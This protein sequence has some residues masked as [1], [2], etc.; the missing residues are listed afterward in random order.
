M[1]ADPTTNVASTEPL[2]CPSCCAK[3]RDSGATDSDPPSRS[4]PPASSVCSR[5][6][7]R[8]EHQ[9]LLLSVL[10]RVTTANYDVVKKELLDQICPLSEQDDVETVVQS[11]YEKAVQPDEDL[12]TGLYAKLFADVIE[13]ETP[14]VAAMLRNAIRH[15]CVEQL[16]GPTALS[17]P[18]DNTT[19]AAH[20]TVCPPPCL[21]P[22]LV[23]GCT[24]TNEDPPGDEQNAS[25]VES[26]GR[27][28]VETVTIDDAGDMP[29]ALHPRRT[30]DNAARRQQR[31]RDRHRRNVAFLG[32]LFTCDVVDGDVM[33]EA[34]QYL[35][36][37]G[38][39]ASRD[40]PS[41]AAA[42]ASTASGEQPAATT[43]GGEVG[44]TSGTVRAAA[45]HIVHADVDE[46]RLTMFADVLPS[47]VAHLSSDA[48]GRL[49]QYLSRVR[50]LI[51]TA[52][53]MTASSSE[54]VV[55]A[56]EGEEEGSIRPT[57]VD[58]DTKA[59][60]ALSSRQQGIS[61]RTA[62]LLQNLIDRAADDW[63]ARKPGPR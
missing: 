62:V 8:S 12:F 9:R 53:A 25:R 37:Q 48:T 59:P 3:Q 46:L 21:R 7:R 15:R 10:N 20:S 29:D 41:P 4:S 27:R 38:V 57:T 16:H 35:L 61:R 18:S 55:P 40:G 24:P 34:L 44:A 49:P 26:D 33:D 45:A 19:G 30:V 50:E 56:K 23:A 11:F 22:H 63:R 52:Y 58:D 17:D 32:H 2:H 42:A 14:T 47:V 5:C 43:S 54:P 1:A 28:A 13:H 31:H 60:P 36:F 39:V 51:S 6:Q